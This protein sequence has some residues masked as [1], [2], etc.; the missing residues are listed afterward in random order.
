MAH[1]AHLGTTGLYIKQFHAND[2]SRS[3]ISARICLKNLFYM[4]I[5][6]I[7]QRFHK[8]NSMHQ[9]QFMILFLGETTKL[10]I[11]LMYYSDFYLPKSYYRI[12][13]QNLNQYGYGFSTTKSFEKAISLR[14]DNFMFIL[15]LKS[16]YV[17]MP[18]AHSIILTR[19]SLKVW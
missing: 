18:I 8:F 6:W 5:N 16:T 9:S 15:S 11:R 13:I 4:H 12:L 7:I 2:V 17:Y 1:P 10:K 3:L 19:N 14:D